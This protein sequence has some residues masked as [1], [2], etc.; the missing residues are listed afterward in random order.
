MTTKIVFSSISG[1]Y[2]VSQ[3]SILTAIK[4]SFPDG[5]DFDIY[6]GNSGGAI[7][8][9]L[10]LQYNGTK[11]SVER[12]LYSISSSMFISPW[13]S[14]NIPFSSVASRMFSVFKSSFYNDGKGSKDVLRSFF[15][16]RQLSQTEVWMGKFNIE[17]N[18]NALLCTSNTT[19]SVLRPYINDDY[20]KE[21]SSVESIRYADGNID[22]ISETLNATSSIPGYRPGVK[23]NN[24]EYMD[25]GIGSASSGGLLMN[26]IWRHSQATG[27]NYQFFYVIGP[28]FTDDTESKKTHWV[29]E[30]GT[31]VKQFTR[32]SIY[33]ERQAL[34]ELWLRINSQND[35]TNLTTSTIRSR[36]DLST[37]FTTNATGSYFITCYAKNRKVNIINFDRQEL[38][39]TFDDCFDNVYFEVYLAPTG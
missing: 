20:V 6:F 13:V 7:S 30:L 2:F 39:D 8:N 21:F 23:I 31:A 3:T 15:T 5:Q 14:T 34:F 16:K 28:D 1:G 35:T 18:K 24:V 4:T 27:N 37:F 9:L 12:V 25:G 19:K 17:T 22:D 26:S 36:S 29:Q 10:S 11:E 38:K 33:R 32:T